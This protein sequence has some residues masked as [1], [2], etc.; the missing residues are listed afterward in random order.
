MQECSRE[1][2]KQLLIKICNIKEHN[3][4]EVRL[5]TQ[6]VNTKGGETT[7]EDPITTNIHPDI[8]NTV[9][10]ID[11]IFADPSNNYPNSDNNITKT[12]WNI[13]KNTQQLLKS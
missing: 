9:P 13:P 5:D 6:S 2:I 4:M 12:N 10:K 7:G 1:K 11:N 8:S 3:D